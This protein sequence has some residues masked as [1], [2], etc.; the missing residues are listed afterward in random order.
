M[1]LV[2]HDITE[3]TTEDQTATGVQTFDLSKDGVFQQ[4][5][6]VT[7]D[8]NPV[9]AEDP[10]VLSIGTLLTLLDKATQKGLAVP[11]THSAVWRAIINNTRNSI[12]AHNFS[13]SLVNSETAP[14]G[15]L[16]ITVRFHPALR[17]LNPEEQIVEVKRSRELYTRESY[18]ELFQLLQHIQYSFTCE[19]D[20][21]VIDVYN[22]N[23]FFTMAA[24]QVVDSWI[25][26]NS[27]TDAIISLGG[28]K[29][30]GYY[31]YPNFLLGEPESRAETVEAVLR[32]QLPE[33]VGIRIDTLGIP[34]LF[35]EQD[36]EK[37]VSIDTIQNALYKAAQALESDFIG[38]QN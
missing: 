8:F 14:V 9:L 32:K 1:R 7:S 5:L 19:G 12:G 6:K 35:I 38:P 21:L 20:Q 16:D 11:N 28:G 17:E 3:S 34:T 26:K 24:E 29:M 36:A 10:T 23:P 4:T 25:T 30:A 2:S 37:A 18:V 27:T 22:P 33:T 15:S 13:Q 31:A